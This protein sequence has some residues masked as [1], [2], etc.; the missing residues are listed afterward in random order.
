MGFIISFLSI[1]TAF[2][3]LALLGHR[4]DR[5]YK[6]ITSSRRE[7]LIAALPVYAVM[8]LFVIMGLTWW[9]VLTQVTGAMI[10]VCM[11]SIV[12]LLFYGSATLFPWL[13]RI[14]S[15]GSRLKDSKLVERVFDLAGELGVKVEKIIVLSWKNLKVANALQVGS[16]RFSIYISDYIIENLTPLQ[17]EAVIAHELAHA[18]K[19]HLLKNLLFTLPTV[20]IGMNLLL[21]SWVNCAGAFSLIIAIAG[22]ASLLAG[23]VIVTPLRRKFELQADAL[24][25]KVLGNTEPLITAL[26]RISELNLIPTKYPRVIEWGLPHPSIETRI[27]K[28][29]MI[30]IKQKE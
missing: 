13:L 7:Y 16:R 12:I 5:K 2:V 30:K 14:R 9:T 8:L 22:I 11:N 18:K 17:I 24:A 23:N 1:T 4:V 19:R 15:R 26:Q 28:L 21:Y 10:F 29:K 6:R 27:K 25:A 3:S 20:L